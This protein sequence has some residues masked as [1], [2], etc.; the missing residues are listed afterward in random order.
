MVDT[1]LL[2][3][4][5]RLGGAVLELQPPHFHFQLFWWR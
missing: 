1:L 3:A 4:G 2:R 5:R